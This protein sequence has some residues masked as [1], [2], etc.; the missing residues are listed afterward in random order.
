[1]LKKY[2]ALLLTFLA[3]ILARVSI[4]AQDIPD[5]EAFQKTDRILILA[6]HPDD[7]AIGGAGV[8]QHALSAG[9]QVKIVYLT[10]S[11]H[12]ELAFIVYEKRLTFRKGEF[13][14]MGQLRCKEAIN[15]MKL[16][17]LNERDLI[18][19]G[20]PDFGTFTI[21]SQFWQTDKPFRNLLTRTSSVPYKN[22]L[23]FGSPYVG[24]SILNDLKKI[25]LDY[26]PT[27]ILVSHPAD[28][29]L[30]H[31]TFYLFLRVALLDLNKQISPV[32]V[33]PYLIHCVGWPKPR[34]YH[35]ELDLVPPKNFLDSQASWL[36]S[37]LTP[38]E[39]EKKHQAILCYRSQTASHAFYLL[40]FAR[41]NELFGNYP[42]IELA[43]QASL[44]E[45]APEFFGSTR[46]FEDSED[47]GMLSRDSFIEG[48]GEVGYAIVDH[49]L[50]IRVDK[51]KKSI[52]GLSFM[53]YVFGYNDKVPFSSMPKIRILIKGK[54]HRIYDGKKKVASPVGFLL[55]T[56][57]EEVVVHIPLTLL[58]D[59]GLILT[60]LKAYSG[61]LPVDATGFR[62]IVIK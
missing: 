22:D 27:K 55:D 62:E 14:H 8:I 10:N 37:N 30:D 20:Y 54:K 4:Y 60:S 35:P 61:R 23:S 47:E 53:L 17:G 12:N 18:F 46:I 41:K 51:T 52:K 32:K 16:L 24:E 38:E 19:L 15:A 13:L 50:V 31:K 48:Q 25:L 2:P 39:L 29:N 21:F 33:Y 40:A 45:K 1:M 28:V 42:Q 5:I 59:P 6:P 44:K 9:A 49:C 36:K 3:I 56:D 58:G 11:D 7:E 43:R 26:K 57:S 34:H